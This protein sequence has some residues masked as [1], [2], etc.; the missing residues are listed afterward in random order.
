MIMWG[1]RGECALLQLDHSR[2]FPCTGIARAY[3]PVPLMLM[4]GYR[5]SLCTG[6]AY[7]YVL[8]PLMLMYWHRGA[9]VLVP[10][11]RMY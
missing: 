4:Y 1:M 6:T 11:M 5:S 2:G 10:L 9:N 8:A 3:V 7:A